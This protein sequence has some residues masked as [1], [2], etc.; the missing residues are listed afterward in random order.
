[1]LQSDFVANRV[2]QIKKYTSNSQWRY[3]KSEDNIAAY[4]SRG[5]KIEELL[6]IDLT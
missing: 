1:M 2:Q 5:V 3:V 6:K 4:V